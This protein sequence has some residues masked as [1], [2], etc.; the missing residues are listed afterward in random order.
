MSLYSVVGQVRMLTP[1]LVRHKSQ[2]MWPK[3]FVEPI[4]DKAE[5]KELRKDKNLFDSRLIQ[6]VMSAPNDA[7][8]SLFA[9]P[10][11]RR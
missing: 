5:I 7:N 3:G 6:P 10:M 9:D 2:L 1:F 11:V 4:T 8:C